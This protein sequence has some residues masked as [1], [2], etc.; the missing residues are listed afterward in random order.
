MPG[1]PLQITLKVTGLDQAKSD[2]GEFASTGKKSF[3]ELQAQARAASDSA[4]TTDKALS[5]VA[6][7]VRSMAAEMDPAGA[8]SLRL[9]NQI[10]DLN[11]AVSAN[12]ISADQHTLMMAALQKQ[13]VS[14]TG[15]AN[16]NTKAFS[17]NRAGMMELQA[18]GINSFQALASGMSPLRV[19]TMEGA[20]AFGA[21]AQG[22]TGVMGVLR[23]IV[24]PTGLAVTALAGLAAGFAAL[25]LHAANNES[26]LR[27]FNLALGTV[28]DRSS[29][30]IQAMQA[31]ALALRSMGV[32]AADAN[33]AMADLARNP[34]INPSA[35]GELQAIGADLGA[36][37]G[38][39]PDEGLK[40]L[41]S[42][43]N[44]GV[45]AM[46]KLGVETRSMTD[47][48]A[49]QV[50]IMKQHG[51][52]VAALNLAL[53]DLKAGIQGAKDQLDPSTAAAEKLRTEW[54]R[55]TV[56]LADGQAFKVA[57]DGL[58]QLLADLTN[59]I[60]KG[61][62]PQGWML[63]SLASS[64]PV[65]AAIVSGAQLG[66]AMPSLPSLGNPVANQAEFANA[67]AARG[68]QV[69][70]GGAGVSNFAAGTP[71]M[72]A[73]M[74]SLWLVESGNRQ[75]GPG[76]GVI[77]SP[78]G[79]IGVGQLMPSTAAGLGVN[80]YDEAQNRAGSTQLM[81]GLIAKYG[82]V[83]T[84]LMAYNWGEG[85]VDKYLAGFKGLP[86]S[87]AGYANSVL[88]GAG[89]VNNPALVGS[90]QANGIK[91]G[92]IGA[93]SVAGTV[94]DP[95]AIAK[96]KAA[97]DA[98]GISEQQQV[99]ILAAVG[100]EQQ[101]LTAYF[102]AYNAAIGQS[103]E[104][105]QA[106]TEGMRAYQKSMAETTVTQQRTIDETA[107]Q[108]AS[109]DALAAAELKGAGEVQKVEAAEKVRAATRGIANEA[110]RQAIAQQIA[111][112]TAI[113][114]LRAANAVQYQQDQEL[115]IATKQ[116]ELALETDPNVIQAGQLAIQHLQ[117]EVALRSK[118][119]NDGL[120]Q[121]R[122]Q[123]ADAIR[124]VAAD[125]AAL[126]AIRDKAKSVAD[127][128]AQFFVDGFANIDQGGKSVF[129][130]LWDSVE[131]GAKRL[132]ANIAADFLKQQIILPVTT[133]I[134]GSAPGLFGL[135]TPGGSGA[136]GGS[137]TLGNLSTTASLAKNGS[138]LFGL[139]DFFGGIKSGINSF[140]TSLGFAEPSIGG[141]SASEM[142]ALGIPGV[143][144]GI[145]GGLTLTGAL[146]IAGIAGA[147]VGLISSLVPG[148]FGNNKPSNN[149]T[150]G[151]INLAT[152]ATSGYASGGVAANDQTFQQLQNSIATFTQQ[153]Q[154]L[155]GGVVRGSVN[156]QAGSRDGIKVGYNFA[157]TS[158]TISGQDAA[159]VESQV[160]QL[161]FQ[162]LDLSG[163]SSVMQKALAGITDPSQ[164]QAAAQAAA[165]AQA[166][167]DS[168]SKAVSDAV[169]QV[170][171]Q[172]D[173][174]GPYAQ[175]MQALN[176]K[177][178]Q[179]TD[180][181]NKYGLSLDPINQAL[182]L[183]TQQLQAGFQD[184][185][186]RAY[187]SASG[188]DFINQLQDLSAQRNLTLGDAAALG[189]GGTNATTDQI[190]A[191]YKAAVNSILGGLDPTQL[192]IA[193]NNLEGLPPVTAQLIQSFM[194]V[195]AAADKSAQATGD[196]SSAA[197]AAAAALQK[198]SAGQSLRDF[199]NSLNTSGSTTNPDAAL[200]AAN[201]NF[202]QQLA[203]AQAGR[204]DVNS[205]I[206]AA[207]TL[208]DDALGYFGSGQRAQAIIAAIRGSLSQLGETQAYDQSIGGLPAATFYSLG[209]YGGPAYQ[210]AGN[211]NGAAFTAAVSS[212]SDGAALLRDIKEL[213]DKMNG[214]L[215]AL[216]S[217]TAHAGDDQKA[218]LQDID[219]STG[220]AAS[221]LR[222]IAG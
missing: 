189:L 59:L 143:D 85:N 93:A 5:G 4:A 38:I 210:F 92:A 98:L 104:G 41:S 40:T 180:E 58:T 90:L 216:L 82:D 113:A 128:V 11:R 9:R 83:S 80:P 165:Q 138:D 188:T 55:L 103:R 202:A 173:A 129:K 74:N 20:Q 96:S 24:T 197:D 22:G 84:A 72:T 190:D 109:Q 214:K 89:L 175:A 141:L 198:I 17:L 152:G 217:M 218:L 77:T 101:A 47:D 88:A 148:L 110:Q 137:S 181:A 79:A 16:D 200:A 157:D 25:E 70:F 39:G 136:A 76:G 203:L 135:A 42:A 13:F 15:T 2:L 162:H 46:V 155:T 191:T 219:S 144:T 34:I 177:I 52:Q 63:Q 56:A 156:P 78:A 30:A 119:K 19:A 150:G 222:R 207:G 199:V 163:A 68:G 187:R 196:A 64:N 172:T 62:G 112:E 7:R 213:L 195:A 6:N 114:N 167:Y 36:R 168:V 21:F 161:I 134:V 121:E 31:G 106:D 91:F 43:L 44:G 3:A 170:D 65:I 182:A 193:M 132:V 122:L 131:A 140:G 94:Q 166:D 105:W 111:D 215:D 29:A 142:A 185:I 100:Q 18:A 49:A 154:Q 50:L 48:E 10:T 147:G 146:G 33:K 178:G 124:R 171:K 149:S 86:A 211:D 212:F 169:S 192:K 174:L 1:S 87:V 61:Q 184:Q 183:G 176:D 127:D 53:G 206:G 108:I 71:T 123:E 118:I 37:L 14:L 60:T 23:S 220:T 194:D 67:L 158:G 99:K 95:T 208:R 205:L 159:T 26:A 115:A 153:I 66:A 32:A 69:A 75:F 151:V 201:D 116:R 164:I 35:I 54:N 51:D 81:Q 97:L 209:D 186:S 73:L 160:Q 133:A 125:T 204:I 145:F 8:A 139:G 12:I 27:Q 179:L 102:Q 120:V 126:N 107:R 221:L 130:S 57:H 45:E 117:D 28:G